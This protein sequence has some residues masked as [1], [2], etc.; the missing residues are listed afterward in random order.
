MSLSDETRALQQSAIAFARQALNHDMI[1]A[2][3]PRLSF[4]LSAYHT[5][6][7][8]HWVNENI[9]PPELIDA[10][11]WQIGQA[12]SANAALELLAQRA[13]NEAA[14]WP[15]FAE[16]DCYACHHELRDPS[17]RQ[18]RSS[19]RIAGS[20]PWGTWYY[21]LV[22]EALANGPS[23]MDLAGRLEALSR[24]MGRPYPDRESVSEA[25]GDVRQ[26]IAKLASAPANQLVANGEESIALLRRLSRPDVTADMGNW[27]AAAQRFL[28]LAAARYSSAHALQSNEA[29]QAGAD[30]IAAK[31]RALRDR[32][33][34][35]VAGD[36]SPYLSP[37]DFVPNE[38]AAEVLTTIHK[39]LEN[40]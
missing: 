5:N 17:W 26:E 8:K 2:G 11:L 15:E 10:Q 1:A 40:R 36:G 28:A 7:K 3:H 29:T 32:L 27:D 20:Y 16:Y 6:L 14:P 37:R 33:H 9:T 39:L 35:P 19:G 23:Q 31:L 18:A 4:E 12:A 24:E 30:E 38:G 22:P 13:A 25:A 21:S 34:F